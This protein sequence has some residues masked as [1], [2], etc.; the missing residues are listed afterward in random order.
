MKIGTFFYDLYFKEQPSSTE[1]QQNG[2]IFR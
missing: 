2:E 1:A